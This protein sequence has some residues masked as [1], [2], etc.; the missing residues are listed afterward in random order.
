M[1]KKVNKAEN[2]SNMMNA[3]WYIKPLW[4]LLALIEHFFI[5]DDIPSGPK[6]SIILTSQN[7][8]KNKAPII[9]N[10][11]KDERIGKFII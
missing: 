11:I 10:K 5:N 2:P 9:G 4:N 1:I 6:P 7:F 8:H 3:Y